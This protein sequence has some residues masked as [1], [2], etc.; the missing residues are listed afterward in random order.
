MI[1][2]FDSGIGG[3]TIAKELLRRGPEYSFVYLGDTA[4]MPYGN[5]SQELIYAF[6]QQAVSYLMAR[7]CSLVILA[8]NT[9]SSEALRK[10]Q[11]E[12]LPKHYPNRRI[13]GV[14]RPLAEAAVAESKSG[15]IG[16]VGTRGTISS[17]AYERELKTLRPD[18][19]IFQQ[20][21]PLLVPLVEEG[22]Q[23]RPETTRIVRNYLRPLKQQHIDTLVL[24]CTHYPMLQRQFVQAA[25]KRVRVIDAPA[26][27]VKK[28]SDYLQRHPNID[29]EL[30]KTKT[31]TFLATDVYPTLEQTASRWLGQAVKFERVDIEST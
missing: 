23:Q 8:C 2:I 15:R 25:G 28:L 22:W 24:G 27:V 18:V 30:D 6:T 3:L 14:I 29:Q 4:R 16:V 11:Q 19:K 13:L 9:A 12:W 17:G 10:L 7:G 20:A 1:G 31:R 21:A 26:A 5:R